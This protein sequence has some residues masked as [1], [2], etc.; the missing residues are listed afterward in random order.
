[1]PT[2]P[3]S[4]GRRERNKQA[5]LE[6]ITAAASALFAEHGVDD[7]TTQQ[8]AE[9]A[10]IGAG[11]LFL[12]AKTKGELLLLVQNTLYVEA[13]E[14]GRAA[15]SA[16]ASLPEAVLALITPIVEC[17]RT[18]IDNGRTYLR[19]MVFG[20]PTEPH[21]AEALSIVARTDEAMAAIL[22]KHSSVDEPQALELARVISAVMF[23][24][25]AASVNAGSS[26]EEI[27]SSIRSQIAVIL[28][29]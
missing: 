18:Q 10:D 25:M 22:T 23:V 24:T 1:M 19:E 13:L 16:S 29:R 3:Q 17:N 14:R 4:L 7:V 21:H 5:K 12:Y 28:P 26:T 11:T 15:A 20:D 8:I 6:R 9:A 27:L 2:A